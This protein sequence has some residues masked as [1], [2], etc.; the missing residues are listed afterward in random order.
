MLRWALIFFIIALIAAGL[1]FTG[2]AG[3]AAGIAKIL[4]WLFVGILLLV[5]LTALIGGGPRP[6]DVA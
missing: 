3:A 4:F 2:V 1:G 6:R 5:L